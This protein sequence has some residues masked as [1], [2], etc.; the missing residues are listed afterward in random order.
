[1]FKVKTNKHRSVYQKIV[2]SL[3]LIVPWYLQ[4][5]NFKFNILILKFHNWQ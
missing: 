4:N 5:S 1:M 2:L 3:N